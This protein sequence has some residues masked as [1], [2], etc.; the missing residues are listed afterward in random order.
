MRSAQGTQRRAEPDETAVTVL[1][2]SR[3]RRPR[4]A[5]AESFRPVAC[6]RRAAGSGGDQA[7]FGAALGISGWPLIVLI[8]S[9]RLLRPSPAHCGCIHVA[10]AHRN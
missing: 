5:A 2:R 6:G 1:H 4:P 8:T 9:G 7:L 3:P 10:G